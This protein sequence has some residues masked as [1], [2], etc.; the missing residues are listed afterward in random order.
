MA[1]LGQAINVL[2]SLFLTRASD[3]ALVKTPVFYVFKM[4]A[5]HHE[6]GAKWAPSTLA[7]ENVRGN[8]KDIPVISAGTTVDGQGRVNLSLANVDLASARTIQI[9][10]NSGKTGYTVSSAQVITGP[11]KDSHNDF[12]QPEVVNI[13]TLASSSCTISGNTLQV[14]LPSKSVVMLVLQ[15]Q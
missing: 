8:N 15:P 13:Q 3:G 11:A 7:T 6:A 12:A 2:Q 9:T 4:L 10:L 14:T 5:P 1:G